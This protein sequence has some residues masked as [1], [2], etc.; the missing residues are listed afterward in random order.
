[1]FHSRSSVSARYRLI[2][3]DIVVLF[4]NISSPEPVR[5]GESSCS[6]SVVH[7]SG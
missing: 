6:E 3:K 4:A 5:H 2:G 1:M 7:V